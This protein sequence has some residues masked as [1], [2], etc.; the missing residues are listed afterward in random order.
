MQNPFE[1]I[2]AR[3]SNIEALLLDIRHQPPVAPTISPDEDQPISVEQAAQFLNI[4]PQTIYQNINKIPHEKRHGRLYFT[5]RT[6]RAYL[7]QSAV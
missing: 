6:L 1:I 4:K 7:S 5:R 3:L 2:S